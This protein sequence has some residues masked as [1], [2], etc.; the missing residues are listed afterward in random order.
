MYG[1][2]VIIQAQTLA[3]VL[4]APVLCVVAGRSVGQ[5]ASAVP[6]AP[7]RTELWL[8]RALMLWDQHASSDRGGAMSRSTIG[9]HGA[10]YCSPAV[11]S[12]APS[13]SFDK[14]RRAFPR[15]SRAGSRSDFSASRPRPC[16]RCWSAFG[17]RTRSIPSPAMR[18][19]RQPACGYGGGD[20]SASRW[21][22]ACILSFPLWIRPSFGSGPRSVRCRRLNFG[23]LS[24]IFPGWR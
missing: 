15:R 6:P 18:S 2:A 17:P 24:Q 4:F 23:V 14:K 13:M 5:V 3:A 11:R 20:S 19:A 8:G 12:R 7:A 10:D 22:D 1:D 21:F 9:R 16:G